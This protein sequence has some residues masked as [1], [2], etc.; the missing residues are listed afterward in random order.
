MVYT[1]SKKRS[2]GVLAAAIFVGSLFAQETTFQDRLAQT[3][4][5]SARRK[6]YILQQLSG[7]PI[8]EK[9]QRNDLALI[10]KLLVGKCDKLVQIDT[11]EDISAQLGAIH[12]QFGEI[13][14]L[15]NSIDTKPA[16]ALAEQLKSLIEQDKELDAAERT[17]LS[18]QAQKELAE[19]AKRLEKTQDPNALYK[20]MGFGAL[21]LAAGYAIA[22]HFKFEQKLD[23]LHRGLFAIAYAA[24][25][26][27][28]LGGVV[29][30][31]FDKFSE[32]EEK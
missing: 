14:K 5:E 13:V 16:V 12:D 19:L 17:A 4:Q 15:I 27:H 1:H 25:V 10:S 29:K 6:H 11:D 23:P 30:F 7:F 2:L 18:E 22:L 21:S 20:K 8:L 32:E 28:G 3:L 9:K 31:A 26:Y 24:L